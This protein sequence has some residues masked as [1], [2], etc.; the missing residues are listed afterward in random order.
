[1]LDQTR[2]APALRP[3]LRLV[4]GEKSTRARSAPVTI[5]ASRHMGQVVAEAGVL[6]APPTIYPEPSA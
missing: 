4:N 2:D 3:A 6:A 5:R 1:M